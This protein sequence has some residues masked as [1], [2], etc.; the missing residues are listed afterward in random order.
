M[1]A[2]SRALIYKPPAQRARDGIWTRTPLQVEG[3]HKPA[4]YRPYAGVLS[5]YP[6]SVRAHRPPRR[7]DVARSGQCRQIPRPFRDLHRSGPPASPKVAEIEASTRVGSFTDSGRFARC[8]SSS[9]NE[10]RR[11]RSILVALAAVLEK[12]DAVTSSRRPRLS[13]QF[14]SLPFRHVLTRM[15][16]TPLR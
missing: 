15:I 11:R 3:G 6:R 1:A 2:A 12:P 14:E 10:C 4:V 9:T 16:M 8:G 5:G 7:S 13:A